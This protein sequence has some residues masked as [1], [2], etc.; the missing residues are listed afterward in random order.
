MIKIAYIY[1]ALLTVGGVDRMLTSKANYM[2]DHLGYDVYIITD[3]QQGR[4]PVFPLSPK[5]QHI[6][7]ETNFDKQYHHRILVRACYYFALMHQYKK[8]LIKLLD[9]INPDIV[10]TTVGREM[11]FIGSLKRSGRKVIGEIHIAKRFM[12]NF[13]LMIEQGGIKAMVAKYWTRKQERNVS[14]LDRLV[15]LTENDAKAW[16]GIAKTEVIPNFSPVSSSK[17]SLRNATFKRAIAVGRYEE[18]KGFDILIDAWAIVHEKHRDWTIDIFGQGTL[19]GQLEEQIKRKGLQGIVN[20]MPPTD[21]IK[22]EYESSDF[23]VLS[24]RFEGFGLVLVEAMSCGTPCVSFDC[25][26]GPHDIIKDNE[27]GL[28]VAN[29]NVD[30]LAEGICYMIENP[31]ER[32]IMGNA[33]RKNVKRYSIDAIM[34]RWDEFFKS[35]VKE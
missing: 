14:K 15:V 26:N 20:L 25:P 30:A 4:P 12:R 11:D 31:E 6:D 17:V 9:E 22:K 27:D 8:R 32:I 34:A 29:G 21:E 7:L 2:A 33:A 1:T 24:S 19:K 35:L 16:H 5:V 13:H 23:F 10:D 3:S 28:L 18:Q